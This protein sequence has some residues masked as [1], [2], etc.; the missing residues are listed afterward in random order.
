[1]GETQ[2]GQVPLNRTRQGVMPPVK[3]GLGGFTRLS[4]VIPVKNM[5]G[6]VL[7]HMKGHEGNLPIVTHI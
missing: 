3:S 5:D 4:R 2:L 7:A 6:S 1:M